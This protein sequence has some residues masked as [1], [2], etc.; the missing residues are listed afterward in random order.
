MAGLLIPADLNV[1]GYAD[2][3]DKNYFDVKATGLLPNTGYGFQF[4]WVFEDGTTSDW[5]ATRYV[6]TDLIST[7]GQPD[8]GVNDVV[9]GAGYIKVNWS[10]TSQGSP[11]T[12]ISRVDVYISGAPFDGTK[13]AETFVTSG[14][15]TIAAPGG[16]YIVKLQAIRPDGTTS[17]LFSLSRTVVVTDIVT[18]TIQDP[19][20]PNGFS[21][22]R[23]L[24]GIQVN[25]AGT[26]ANGTFTGFQA[27]KIY[28]GNSATA[29]AGTY[30]EAGVM[31]GNNLKNTITIPVDGTYLNYDTPVYIHAAAV[32]KN[33]TV[34]T[35]QQNVA[36]EPLGARSA[37]PSDLANQIIT[38][39]K[40]VDAAITEA[41]IATS[42][43]TTTKIADDAITSS[44]IIANAI[45][46]DK[47]V[48]SAIT[49]DKIAANAIT[50]GKIS[51]GSIDVTK[52]AAGTISV[53]N[54]EAGLITSTSYIR[55]GASTGA[56]VEIS[57]SNITNGPSAGFYIY[58]STGVA[59][60]SAPLAGGLSITG[61][62]TFSGNLQGAGGTFTGAL[63]VGTQNAGG[64][65]PFSVSNNGYM[66]TINAS[67]GGFIIDDTS[68]S[69][70]NNTFQ[71]N[72]TNG[73]LA[74][75]T[76][77]DSHIEID[78]TNGIIHKNNSSATGNFQLTPTGSL[79][80]GSS[81]GSN[82]FSWTGSAL[83][84]K[85]TSVSF[86]GD[87]ASSF[88]VNSNG[89]SLIGNP[90]TSGSGTDTWAAYSGGTQ[91]LANSTGLHMYGIPV[92]QDAD[93]AYRAQGAYDPHPGYRKGS[94]GQDL[95][96]LGAVGRQRMV[97]E[98]PETGE[99][100]M[101]MAVYYRATGN[102]DPGY[103]SG[104]VGDLWV[105]Y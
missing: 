56:R 95:Y 101:G 61:G 58:D 85:S 25:W 19:T 68:I 11:I 17:S 100:Q 42:A 39:A 59:I 10:G 32:N 1:K 92:Q 12:N 103:T 30:K 87:S 76:I 64:L 26:Y 82:Y 37:I 28:V 21:I 27:I 7:P 73:R 63:N 48:S 14:T 66:R 67:I 102:S 20:N 62:G 50:A 2:P 55:A 98:R 80:L 36:N 88:T 9:G 31:T 45:T 83:T 90:R 99:L 86:I 54:L 6:L 91:I 53:N 29:T 52:L 16:T 4:Q 43:I 97:V 41:K 70:N 84:V 38:N 105:V 71:M 60:L 15:K 5:S 93:I 40:L 34:G 94:G 3:S 69:A 8:L 81:S 57:S 24:S 96:P 13:P 33:G 79:T 74:V 18:E 75:G 46:A 77:T 49:A 47:I 65:Y 72:S 78:G 89:I 44:K 104:Y 51:A 22:D 35:I 23:I